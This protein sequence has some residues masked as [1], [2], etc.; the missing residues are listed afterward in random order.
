MFDAVKSCRGL[1]RGAENRRKS[2]RAQSHCTGPQRGG[3]LGCCLQCDEAQSKLRIAREFEELRA[4]AHRFGDRN[5]YEGAVFEQKAFKKIRQSFGAPFETPGNAFNKV[6]RREDAAAASGGSGYFA[7]DSPEFF[8]GGGRQWISPF[9]HLGG[10]SPKTTPESN[11][12][13]K[14]LRAALLEAWKCR[15]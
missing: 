2:P 1:W 14:R 5:G 6:G 12:G 11:R 4:E 13:P 15:P 7:V 9:C 8:G 10:T 3:S